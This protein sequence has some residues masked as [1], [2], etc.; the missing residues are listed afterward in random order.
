MEITKRRSFWIG[1]L[2][3]F[4]AGF[5]YAW[6]S[7]WATYKDLEQQNRRR[8]AELKQVKKSIYYCGDIIKQRE[9]IIEWNKQTTLPV[10]EWAV[11]EEGNQ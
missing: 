8:E 11:A 9:D 2:I 6:L 10:P 7:I 5:L 4:L 3:G 1:I